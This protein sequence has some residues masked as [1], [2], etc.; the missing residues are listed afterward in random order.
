MYICVIGISIFK[1]IVDVNT[2]PHSKLDIDEIH[3]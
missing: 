1:F 2:G 3:D